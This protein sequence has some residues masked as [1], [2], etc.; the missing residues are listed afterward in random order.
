MLPARV[1]L[2]D[3]DPFLTRRAR[4]IFD[5]DVDLQ[6]VTSGID[7]LAAAESWRPDVVVLDLLL[8]DGDPFA[9]LDAL[10]GRGRASSPR[11]ICLSKGAGSATRFRTDDG[12]F[13]GILRR[14]AGAEGLREAV[15]AALCA[16]TCM[17]PSAA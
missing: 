1:L 16:K 13:L 15:F 7:A 2:I 8:A 12:Q 3:D 5:D 4:A 9:L 10:G 6:V 14:D 17:G 11:V